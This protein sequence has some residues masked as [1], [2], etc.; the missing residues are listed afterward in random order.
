[1]NNLTEYQEKV[2]NYFLGASLV[3]VTILV[4]YVLR[5]YISALILAMV[6][7]IIFRPL[8]LWLMKK[9]KNREILS[10]LLTTLFILLVIMVPVAIFSSLVFSQLASAINNSNGLFHLNQIQ[11][12]TALTNFNVDLNSYLHNFIGGFVNDIGRYFSSILEFF[13]YV[14]LTIISLFYL[15]KDGLR[16][17]EGIME[18]LPFTKKQ[19]EKLSR[20]L[21]TGIRAVIG[22][23]ILVALLEGVVSGFG[24]W[25]FRVPNPALWGF[26]TFLAALIPTFGTSLVNVPA[27]IYLYLN[28]LTGDAVAL[29]VWYILAISIIDNIIGPRFISGRVKI[30]VLLLIFSIIGGLKLFGPLGFIMGPLVMILFW[31]ILEMFQ[32]KDLVGIGVNPELLE[33]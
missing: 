3:L 25:I 24:F 30:H 19:D 15:F 1:M 7:A 21:A 5:P 2:Q 22:G 11:A 16:I 13:V 6:L 32:E 28:H 14:V 9:T 10:A 29:T 26:V 20:D 18:A 17:K 4:F 33:K 31:S 27:I 23:Y 8:F 12:P